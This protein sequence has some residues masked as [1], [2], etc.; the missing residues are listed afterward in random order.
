MIKKYLGKIELI[1]QRY[2]EKGKQIVPEVCEQKKGHSVRRT[3]NRKEVS[4]E[5]EIHLE[6]CQN[7]NELKKVVDEYIEYYNKFRYQWELKQ[8]ELQ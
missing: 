2:A 7:F 1:K 3:A 4:W 5:E 8:M 6:K